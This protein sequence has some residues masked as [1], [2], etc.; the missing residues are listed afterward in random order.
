MMAIL[1][2]VLAY[3]FAKRFGLVGGQLACLISITVGYFFQVERIRKVTGLHLSSYLKT[4]LVPA[5]ISLS[6]VA[7]CVAGRSLFVDARPLPNILLGVVGCVTAYGIAGA[8]FVR[9]S[10]GVA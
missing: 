8:L 10:R 6:V 4:S 9:R 5:L 3:P 2:I 7:I 1:M